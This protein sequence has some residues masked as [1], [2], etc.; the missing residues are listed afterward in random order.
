MRALKKL[1]AVITVITLIAGIPI[2][3]IALAG[4]PI[5]SLDELRDAATMPDWS[6]QFLMGTILPIVGWIAWVTIAFSF[7]VEIPAQLRGI[8]APR[9]PGLGMQQ[10][11]AS[12]LIAVI[13]S[14]AGGMTATMAS[15]AEMPADVAP[16]SASI[17]QDVT[18]TASDLQETPAPPAAAAQQAEAPTVTVAAGDSLWNLAETH[19]GDGHR[20]GEIQSLNEGVQQADGRTLGSDGW[21]EPGW[22]LAMPADAASATPTAADAQQHT[23]QSGD[24]LWE[25]SQEAYGDGAQYQRIADASPTIHDPNVI[26]PGQ[27]VTVPGAATA[28]AASTAAP[29]PEQQPLASAPADQTPDASSQD[30]TS[31]SAE[32]PNA[33]QQEAETQTAPQSADQLTQSSDTS[34]DESDSI[35]DVFSVSTL[36][37]IGG[38][39]AAGLLSVL[40]I[41][42]ARQ[43]RNRKPG[44]R[45]AM[46]AEADQ[47]LEFEMRAVE[48]PFSMTD[49]DRS[50][51]WLG[52]W[53]AHT[54]GATLPELYAVRVAED[55]LALYLNEPA[56]LPE[57]FVKAV[58]DGT[59]WTIPAH[60][61]PVLDEQ[62]S[63]PY[64]GLVTVGQDHTSAQIL[65]DLERAGAL[66]VTADEHDT[67][68][69]AVNAL[70]VELATT[71]W[72]EDVQITL[73]GLDDRLP[74]ALDTGRVRRI[75]DLPTLMREL[76]ARAAATSE[77]LEQLRAE[78]ISAA[79]S[80]EPD[81]EPFTPEIVL[82]AEQPAPEIASELAALALD[83]P[84]LGIATITAGIIK[85]GWQL[86]IADTE[87]ATLELPDGAGELPLHPQLI[88]QDDY[89][90][91]LSLYGT[92]EESATGEQ[93]TP[94]A[95]REDAAEYAVDVDE[96]APESIPDAAPADPWVRLLGNVTVTGAKGPEPRTASTGT[97]RG[98]LVRA[99]EMIAF[100]SL[101]SGATATAVSEALWPGKTTTGKTAAAN[102][103]GLIA[104]VR[105]WLGT[106]TD[107]DQ[108][109]PPVGKSGYR[110]LG[111]R[112]DWD[113]FRE[114]VGDDVIAANTENLIAALKLVEGQPISGVPDRYYAWAEAA[115]QEMIQQIGDVAHELAE[116]AIE[117]RH[118]SQARLAATVGRMVDPTNELFWRDALRVADLAG[119]NSETDRLVTGL[120]A[121]LDSLDDGYEPEPETAHLISQLQAT[122]R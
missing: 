7:I 57:P 98:S 96:V 31:T 85:G 8:R 60:D 107:G 42:R 90:R 108:Y 105:K 16:D 52:H 81:V 10:K 69:A 111:V 17:S 116:R 24:T 77:T 39:L 47:N 73:V 12:T 75:D 101:N 68:L 32:A 93:I 5:P 46:P 71:P 70:G 45:I 53:A 54:E 117:H 114:L 104:R 56:D 88:Q 49:L 33:M 79:R 91:L 106:T 23:V 59:A 28:P 58:E 43:R 122:A 1:A 82:L 14:G 51:R 55:E 103:N 18:P 63:S 121:M 115:K 3:L 109:V 112:S 35:S 67:A 89:E 100:L 64:P 4:N 66:N 72:A 26:Y 86:A 48:T 94:V 30:D 102:R 62:P 20:W 11:L 9:L 25:I 65:I 120:Y 2:A 50:L 21:L 84:R 119:D 38:V 22:V 80:S 37:G 19:L 27:I 118:L 87:H 41:R 44:Q 29:A 6:G 78:S 15:A 83:I 13:L 92:T 76:K 113:V 97:N 74:K 95:E 61:V 110:L 34:Q 99:T 36:G 40:G